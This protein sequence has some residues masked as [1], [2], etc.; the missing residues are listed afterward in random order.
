[1]KKLEGKTL[2]AK[3]LSSLPARCSAVKAAT[4]RAPS[5]AIINFYPVS[6]SG[7]YARKK[8]AACEKA[9]ISVK[10]LEP[11]PEMPYK[12]FCGLLKELGNDESIDAIMAERP[13][14]AG[15]ERQETW[16]MFPPEKDADG[17]SALNAGRLFQI[18]KFSEIEE[19]GLSVPCT[20]LSVVKLMQYHGIQATG[21]RIAVAGRSSV[22]GKPLAQMLTALNATV[23]LCH[24]GTKDIAAVFRESEIIISAAGKAKWLKKEMLPENAVLIDVG[25]NLDENRKLCGDADPCCAEKCS[26][27]SPVPGGVGP[28]TKALLLE[29]AVKAAERKMK[30]K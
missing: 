28:V 16:D 26:A 8:A 1:M 14:P 19:K 6:P 17:L 15:F 3:I 24:T 22:V 27:M 2:S 11:S 7:I 10:M 30:N 18:K 21:A 13:L 4:G 5:L 12:E 23:T 29:A 9:G 25:T 20:A